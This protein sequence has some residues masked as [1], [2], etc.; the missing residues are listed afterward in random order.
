MLILKKGV[1]VNPHPIPPRYGLGCSTKKIVIFR[2]KPEKT[3]S[4]FIAFFIKPV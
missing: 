3:Q 4:V 2:K 1:G